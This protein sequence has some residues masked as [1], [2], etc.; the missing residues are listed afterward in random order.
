MDR[1]I[2]TSFLFLRESGQLDLVTVKF[3]IM[4]INIQLDEVIISNIVVIGR[5]WWLLLFLMF[6]FITMCSQLDSVLKQFDQLVSIS[7]FS[8]D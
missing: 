7:V 4:I 6:M 2:E 3:V 5:M 1:E 8:V